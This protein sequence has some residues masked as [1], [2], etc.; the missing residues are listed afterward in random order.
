MA[1]TQWKNESMF[2]QFLLLT[3]SLRAQPQAFCGMLGCSHAGMKIGHGKYHSPL[4]RKARQQ[5]R[6]SGI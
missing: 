2:E 1:I 6:K 5:L 3:M 4:L